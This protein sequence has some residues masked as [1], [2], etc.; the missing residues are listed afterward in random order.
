MFILDTVLINVIILALENF[1]KWRDS[2][3]LI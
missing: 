2:V 3:I 1:P